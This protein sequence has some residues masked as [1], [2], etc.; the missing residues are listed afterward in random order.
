MSN[1]T[2]QALGEPDLALAGWKLWIVGRDQEGWLRAWSVCEAPGARVK[3]DGAIVYTAGV[4][5]FLKQLQ[6]LLPGRKGKAVLDNL[7]PNLSAQISMDG[8]GSGRLVVRI[9][10]DS[11]TQ[12]HEFRFTIT[13]SDLPPVI[14]SLEKILRYPASPK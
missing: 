10:P 14:E 4:S 6:E 12:K 11:A 8:R 7:E 5:S 3:T 13:P 2:F 1:R 9:T